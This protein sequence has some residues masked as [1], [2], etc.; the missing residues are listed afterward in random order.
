MSMFHGRFARRVVRRTAV[1][2]V[3]SLAAFVVGVPSVAQAAVSVSRASLSSGSL[4]VEGNGAAASATITVTSPESR[5]TGTADGDGEYKVTASGYRS[6]TCKVTVSDG[7]TT[8]VATLSGCAV[9]AA[10]SLSIVTV[11]PTS[12]AGGTGATG[13]VTLTGAAPAG[14]AVV[15]LNSSSTIATVG[16]SVSMPA[17]ATSVT[18][19]V[20]TSAVT[21]QVAATL[22]ATYLGVSRSTTLT[23]TPLA[24]SAPVLSF[25]GLSH[26]SLSAVGT[27]ANGEI[28]LASV[29]SAPVTV[30]VASSHPNIARVTL[31][32]TAQVASVQVEPGFNQAVFNV[33]HVAAV[34]AAT[35]VTITASAGAVTLTRQLTI[36]PE[37]VFGFFAASTNMGPGFVGSNFVDTATGN[38]T[39]LGTTDA[40]CVSFDIIAGQLPNGL[41]LSDPNAGST[42]C[43][44]DMIV[45]SGV[46]TT[47]QTNT[48]TLRATDDASGA[49]ATIVVT[50]T[51]NP[52]LGIV[53]NAQLPW[54][55]VVGSFSNL[56]IDGSGG[57]RPY[58][59]ARTAGQ[60]PPG[61]SLVQD[62]RDGPLVRIT[63][64]PTTAGTFTF[65][66]RVTDS[67]G[68]TASRSLS[69]TVA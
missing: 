23:V 56:W 51:I 69:V 61:M 18:F 9:T 16:A 5:A 11:A 50:I 10:A 43:K 44:L 42:P 1:V 62:N 53:I 8:V 32:S 29:A 17:G 52:P 41:F 24:A 58:T 15:A 59:W 19:P 13:T 6:S 35:V 46:P 25:L 36:Y 7:R 64:T 26:T 34:T 30:A 57:V 12:V 14:G 63:G 60:L 47:V 54:S 4:R 20:T 31:G 37:P 38:G 68:A 48:F 40:G 66:L 67:K 55:P 33:R 3:L 39:T 45:V 49:Q 27:I 65:T 2:M 21:A 22:T 28:L